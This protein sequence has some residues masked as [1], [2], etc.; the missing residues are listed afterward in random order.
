MRQCLGMKLEDYSNGWTSN[1]PCKF[2]DSVSTS[3][4]LLPVALQSARLKCKT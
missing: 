3:L 1:L 2:N 4:S